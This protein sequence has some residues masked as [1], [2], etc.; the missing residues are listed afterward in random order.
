MLD[1]WHKIKMA[2]EIETLTKHKKLNDKIRSFATNTTRVTHMSGKNNG[3]DSSIMKNTVQS[4]FQSGNQ[5]FKY[6]E[7]MRRREAIADAERSEEE[8]IQAIWKESEFKRIQEILER[9]RAIQ[10]ED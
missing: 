4:S 7:I 9:K 3:K 1:T 2:R 8:K 5:K 6:Q 10:R